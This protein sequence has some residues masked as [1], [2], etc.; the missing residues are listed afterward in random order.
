[1]SASRATYLMTKGIYHKVQEMWIAEQPFL[2]FT[3]MNTYM[4]WTARQ[5][6]T[7]IFG[8]SRIRALKTGAK[9]YDITVSV[10]R[11]KLMYNQLLISYC[12]YFRTTSGRRAV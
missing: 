6:N 10:T 5:F 8:P 11:K 1:M 9:L 4:P 12:S 7:Y 3:Y 2:F